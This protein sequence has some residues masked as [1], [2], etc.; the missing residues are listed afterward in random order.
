MMI[1]IKRTPQTTRHSIIGNNVCAVAGQKC[2]GQVPHLISIKIM[3]VG[4]ISCP[5]LATIGSRAIRWM[6]RCAWKPNVSESINLQSH[7][8]KTVFTKSAI[9]IIFLNRLV[10]RWKLLGM[11][12]GLALSTFNKLRPQWLNWIISLLAKLW[13]RYS[14]RRVS[15][16][17]YLWFAN[18]NQPKVILELLV[19]YVGCFSMNKIFCSLWKCLSISKNCLVVST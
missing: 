4:V 12:G 13:Q 18:V 10:D 1:L 15:F 16:V 3:G 19:V 9:H 6:Q 8:I 14:K 2:S 17:F 11:D 5:A 7:S